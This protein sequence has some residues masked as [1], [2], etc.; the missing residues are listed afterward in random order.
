MTSK[1]E[2]FII[3]CDQL[4]SSICSKKPNTF[5]KVS[6]K[7]R[8]DR[9][10]IYVGRTEEIKRM[11]DPVYNDPI[12]FYFDLNEEYDLL[13]EV[14][15]TIR[16]SIKMRKLIGRGFYS[17]KELLSS[18][19]ASKDLIS[20]CNCRRKQVG[21]CSCSE[22]ISVGTIHVQLQHEIESECDYSM[23]FKGIR[24][25]GVDLTGTAAYFEILQRCNKKWIS[26]YESEYQG[27]FT[28]LKW[29][30]LSIPSD[31]FCD[32]NSN[33]IMKFCCY[34]RSA[35]SIK[36][37]GQFY[38]TTDKLEKHTVFNLV[39]FPQNKIGRAEK[40]GEIHVIDFKKTARPNI[41]QF[42]KSQFIIVQQPIPNRL[43][44]QQKTRGRNLGLTNAVEFKPTCSR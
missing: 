25:S 28:N 18:E 39:F 17:L 5:V 6:A 3:N 26:V 37:I 22:G 40:R 14:A 19:V 42:N 23:A 11:K 32:N 9:D 43:C 7:K 12:S 30:T 38:F 36:L 16:M 33:T 34:Q 29:Q 21:R 10:Y 24:L 2:Y 44:E 27:K 31:E 15:D 35:A 8:Y 4:T 20:P 1:K 13:F 41:Q